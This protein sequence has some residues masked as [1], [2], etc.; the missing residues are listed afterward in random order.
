MYLKNKNDLFNG[1][2]G[3][4]NNIDKFE[5]KMNINFN[6]KEILLNS[7]DF[8]NLIFLCLYSL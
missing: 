2:I 5:S 7:V 6:K 1:D 3:I 8:D 4:I